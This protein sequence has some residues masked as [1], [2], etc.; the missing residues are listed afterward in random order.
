MSGGVSTVL[1]LMYF[2]QTIGFMI[3]D[4]ERVCDPEF[5]GSFAPEKG[6]KRSV[7]AK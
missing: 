3:Q 2:L 1:N 6:Q 5:Q 4:S 7:W